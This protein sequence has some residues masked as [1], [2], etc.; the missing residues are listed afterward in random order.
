MSYGYAESKLH[1]RLKSRQDCS[2]WHCV[3]RILCVHVDLREEAK[4]E[5][6]D[7]LQSEDQET[8]A[9]HGVL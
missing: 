1:E 4:S 6:H 3:H 5:S 9:E 2:L 7:S 8:E